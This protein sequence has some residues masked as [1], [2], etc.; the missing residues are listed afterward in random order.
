MHIHI[1]HHNQ[2]FDIN[3]FD[4]EFYRETY[5]TVPEKEFFS[6]GLG[7][8]DLL[9]SEEFELYRHINFELQKP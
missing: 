5:K 7:D 9:I 1:M 6:E 4:F 2:M 8:L 3:N